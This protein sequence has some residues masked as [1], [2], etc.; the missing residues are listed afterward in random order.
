MNLV[1]G[2]PAYHKFYNFADELRIYQIQEDMVIKLNL[3]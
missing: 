3:I 1:P 2:L